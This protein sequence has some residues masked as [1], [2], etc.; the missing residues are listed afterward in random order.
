MLDHSSIEDPSLIQSIQELIQQYPASEDVIQR[1]I[2]YYNTQDRP[3]KK[4]KKEE[5]LVDVELR[6][7]DVSFQSPARK[8]YDLILTKTELLLYH[9]KLE[10]V[11]FRYSLKLF[12]LGVCV[13]TPEKTQ[14]CFTFGLFLQGEEEDALVFQTQDK[15]DLAW[16]AQ[17]QKEILT[18]DKH[19]VIIDLL[20]THSGLAIEQPTAESP[21]HVV[22]YLKAKDGF[23]FFLPSGIL[24]G[25]KKPTLF[26]PLQNIADHAVTGITQRTFDLVLNP[27]G[28][29]YGRN[30]KESIEFSMISQES[31]GPINTYIKKANSLDQSMSEARKAPNTT[32]ADHHPTQED[33]EDSEEDENFEPSDLED[34]DPLEYDTDA[35]QDSVGSPTTASSPIHENEDM[36]EESD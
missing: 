21:A 28:Q 11:E 32:P 23:L 31:F 6:L 20:K 12:A 25:F 8:K 24:F 15:A 27:S 26:I 10:R 2:S 33:S 1:L 3:N 35:E 19:R 17:G 18:S 30:S 29:V 16:E 9:S 22:A 5:T 14:A 13:P 7:Y 36:L 34:E 4:Q